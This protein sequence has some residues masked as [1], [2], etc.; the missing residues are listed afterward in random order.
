MGSFKFNCPGC[1]QR[2]EVEDGMAGTE[3]E[4]PACGRSLRIPILRK[5]QSGGDDGITV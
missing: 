4:C 5:S 3:A 1:G 2:L